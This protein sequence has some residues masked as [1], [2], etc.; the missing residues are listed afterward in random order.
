MSK[1]PLASREALA[2]NELTGST[3]LGLGV[4]TEVLQGTQRI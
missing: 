4:L 1:V 3:E 2:Q